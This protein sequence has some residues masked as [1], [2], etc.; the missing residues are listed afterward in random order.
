MVPVMGPTVEIV[1][2]RLSS[3]PMKRTCPS[4][5]GLAQPQC[6]RSRLVHVD[7]ARGVDVVLRH[8]VHQVQPE[9]VHGHVQQHGV[10]RFLGPSRCGAIVEAHA[11][12]EM[13]GPTNAES[14]CHAVLLVHSVEDGLHHTR[15][16]WDA[17]LANA[18]APLSQ[19]GN[20]HIAGISRW[21]PLL[22]VVLEPSPD[23]PRRQLRL[24][25]MR[26]PS[27]QVL[28]DRLVVPS[29]QEAQLCV[30][31]L[32]IPQ[33]SRWLVVSS[34]RP[35]GSSVASASA[36]SGGT[37]CSS[38]SVMPWRHHAG[39]FLGGK[40][41]GSSRSEATHSHKACEC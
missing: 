39:R 25:H 16:D 12:K 4:S 11:A 40:V 19:N 14:A 27:R 6:P 7:D 3:A 32:P 18:I 21:A 2:F 33:V 24:E 41:S 17:C 37:P 8:A 13:A 30:I 29:L 28:R 1:R 38:K 22:L 35:I 36:A 10:R 9:L 23:G 26:K 15:E 5:F 34:L 20:E 31:H